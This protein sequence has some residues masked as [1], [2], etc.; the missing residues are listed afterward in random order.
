MSKLTREFGAETLVANF[1]YKNTEGPIINGYDSCYPWSDMTVITDNDGNK[2]LR[3][4]KFYT[5]YV[6]ENGYVCARY[7]S[8]YK[9][10]GDWH[11]NPIFLDSNNK[12]LNSI[13]IACYQVGTDSGTKQMS[14]TGL[15][16][17]LGKELKEMKAWI[18]DINKTDEKYVYSL[19]DIWTHIL[20]QD[21]FIIEYANSNIGDVLPGYCYTEYSNKMLQTG[22]LDKISYH[23]GTTADQDTGVSE[24]Y[25]M[26]YR[27][28]ENIVGNGITILDGIV[29]EGETIKVTIN[30][31]E[32]KAK[33]TRP[34]TSGKVAKL[35][36]DKETKLVFPTVVNDGGTYGDVYRGNSET[37]Q[38]VIVGRRD[39]K[40]YGLFSYGFIDKNSSHQY[41]TYRIIRKQK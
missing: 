24:K 35:S 3:I 41:G 7:I 4:P 6:S 10:D 17:T 15:K 16:V 12:E 29:C 23:T 25:G 33:I 18:N 5:K 40:G 38:I 22:E 21:L 27:Y 9:I 28:L 13:E 37:N 26:K 11:L 34:S 1:A 19:Y 8:Q 30:S 39:D 20:I 31:S 36:F 32:I 14:K 2:W